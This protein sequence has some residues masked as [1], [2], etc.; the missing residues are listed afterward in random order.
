MTQ[1]STAFDYIV[2]GAGAAGCVLA[3]RLSTDP[4]VRVA[5][6]EAGPSDRTFP[7]N[8]KTHLPIGNIFLLPHARY[9]WQHTFTGGAGV[10]HRVIGCPR[11]KLFGGCT[12]VNGSVYIRGHASDYDEWAALG[13]DGWGYD[14]VLEAFK[15]HENRRL[16]A[17][18]WH[19]I[20]GE[21]D[22]QLPASL[23]PLSRAFVDAAVECGHTRND[24]FNGSVQDGYGAYE[25]NQRDGMRLS[26][27]RAFL[28]PVLAR[29]N[30]QVFADTLVERIDLRGARA[31]GITVVHGGQRRALTAS[32]EV[33]VSG[34]A[35]NSPQLL[36]LSGIGPEDQ[37]QRHGIRVHCEL[38]GVGR[39]LQDHPTVYVSTRN[40]GAESYAMSMRTLPR[41]AA[42][43]LRY[44]FGRR[45]MLASNAAEAGGFLRTLPGLARPDVQ[46]TFLVGL[47]GTARTIPREHGFLV[48]VQLLRPATRGHIELASADPQDRPVMHPS[49]L[50]DP[51][52]VA[53]LVRGLR[54]ARRIFSSPALARYASGELEPGRGVESDAALEAAIRAQVTT[55]YHPVGTCRMGPA[56]DAMAVVDARLRVHGIDGLRVADASIMP[57]IVGGNTS[58]PSTMIGERAADFILGRDLPAALAPNGAAADALRPAPMSA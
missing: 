19:G 4:S 10:G 40:P 36:M 35:V 7:L 39:N 6:V 42:S 52:D 45:G 1:T 17:S 32:A 5:L 46:M 56:S 49:F 30:L 18:A 8:V 11:G 25:L 31:V 38:P 43:P 2:I 51:A 16:G 3:N 53:T 20:G 21:L 57:N 28:H 54:E 58:A 27:S 48:L 12:S 15:R 29:P 34:G 55:A 50:D 26:N 37:L 22:V 44:L 41:I 9:N 24:D 23:N 13:N 33:I 47:K 14:A